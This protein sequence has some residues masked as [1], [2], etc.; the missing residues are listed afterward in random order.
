M[1]HPTVISFLAI[2]QVSIH[3]SVK[4]ATASNFYTIDSGLVSIH[5]SVKDAT[6]Q[7]I[8]PVP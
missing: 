8:L 4:D 5:A 2:E 6:F 3:A 1:R 7:Y